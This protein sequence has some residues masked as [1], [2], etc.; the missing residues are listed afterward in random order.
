M[1]MANYIMKLAQNVKVRQRFDLLSLF[2]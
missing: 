2:F 1:H